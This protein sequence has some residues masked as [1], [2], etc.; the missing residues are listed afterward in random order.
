LTALKVLSVYS[1]FDFKIDDMIG[2][3]DFA[4]VIQSGEPQ[5]I[6]EGRRVGA[7]NSN[8]AGYIYCGFNEW[9]FDIACPYPES[10]GLSGMDADVATLHAAATLGPIST[11]PH[12]L[13]AV[14]LGYSDHA[15]AIAEALFAAQVGA[16]EKDGKLYCIS[17][18]P[19]DR[20]PWFVYPGFQLGQVDDPWTL[21]TLN[22]SP[23]YATPGFKR[24]VSHVSAKAAFL[25]HVVRS[26]DYTTRLVDHVRQN[27][28]VQ[29]LGYSPGVSNIT[30]NKLGDYADINTNGI[31]LQAIAF[32]L[33][34]GRAATEWRAQ[35]PN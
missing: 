9:G 8:Y 12:L 10:E 24:S 28:Q 25:W 31:I 32:A 5:T 29:M 11:E 17:E 20:E 1:T 27:A 35:G 34:N 15:R 26:G 19:I 18:G 22:T 14:E 6:S 7:Y 33:N 2:Q 30:D 4:A 23:R 13:E 21:E 3:W 16:Y